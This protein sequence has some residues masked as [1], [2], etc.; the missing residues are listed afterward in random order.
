MAFTINA[1]PTMKAPAATV[2]SLDNRPSLS[3][4]AC[5]NDRSYFDAFLSFE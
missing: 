3:Y 4:D 2:R 5:H 1:I